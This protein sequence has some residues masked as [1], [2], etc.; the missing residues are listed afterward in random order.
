[1]PDTEKVLF[2]DDDEYIRITVEE[3]LSSAGFSVILA[4]SG[5]ECLSILKNGFSGV[6]LMDIM[7]P[8]MDGWETIRE[9]IQNNYA[10][11][12][13]IAMLTAKDVPDPKMEYLKDYVIDYITKPFEPEDLVAVVSYYMSVLKAETC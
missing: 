7:M 11:G 3:I 10:K 9:I 8:G 6:I 4:E 2:V 13:I 5:P 12:T 1:M